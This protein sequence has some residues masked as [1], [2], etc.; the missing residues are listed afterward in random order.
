[1]EFKG[2]RNDVRHLQSSLEG[3]ESSRHTE[4]LDVV[5]IAAMSDQ[6]TKLTAALVE[7]EQKRVTEQQIMS[8]TV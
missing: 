8:E 2:S 6:I 7:S 3:I 4:A 1:M 5:Q